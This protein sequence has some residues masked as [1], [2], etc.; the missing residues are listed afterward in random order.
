VP[1]PSRS[2]A[3]EPTPAIADRERPAVPDV[4]YTELITRAALEAG[5]EDLFRS[6]G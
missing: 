5:Q 4:S 3:A 2:P 6:R 1:Y